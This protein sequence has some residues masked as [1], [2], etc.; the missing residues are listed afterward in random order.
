VEIE[1]LTAAE[2]ARYVKV[3]PRTLLQ[4]AREG[5]IP[6]HRLSGVKRCIYRFLR[7]ELNLMLGVSSADSADGRQ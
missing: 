2:A 5:K 3:K 1:W 6:A 7:S 4:W